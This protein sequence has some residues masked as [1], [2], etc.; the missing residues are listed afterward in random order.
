[1]IFRPLPAS[2]EGASLFD[3]NANRSAFPTIE[4]ALMAVRDRVVTL[5]SGVWMETQNNSLGGT[6]Q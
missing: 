1:M 3:L 6:I 2:A 5:H 4:T